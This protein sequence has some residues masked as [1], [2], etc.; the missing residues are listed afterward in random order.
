MVAETETAFARIIRAPKVYGLDGA[1][2]RGGWHWVEAVAVEFEVL[3]ALHV[4]GAIEL[5]RM[6]LPQ[7]WEGGTARNSLRRGCA[8]FHW[9]RIAS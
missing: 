6:D 7:V 8:E 2:H 4:E 9:V 1:A 5:R 3:W